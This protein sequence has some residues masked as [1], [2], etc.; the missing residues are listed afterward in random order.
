LAA[1]GG[2]GKG[3][4]VESPGVKAGARWWVLA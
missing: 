4:D 1:G 2:R 3:E